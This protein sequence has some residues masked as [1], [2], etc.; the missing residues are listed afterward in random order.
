[1]FAPGGYVGVDI[2]F[3][4]S[5]YLITSILVRDISNGRFSL[6]TF[7]ERRCR[8]ILPPLV[9]VLLGT[10][11][12]AYIYLL[13]V[14][15]IDYAKSLCATVFSASN[16]Y[17]WTK[18]SYFSASG[19]LLHTWS[20][21]VEEQFYVVFPL[22][23]ATVYRYKR[24]WMARAIVVVAILSFC[25]S[26]Y[27]QYRWPT[28]N[29][30]MPTT[31]AWEL[32]VGSIVALRAFPHP[33]KPLTRAMIAALGLASMLVPILTYTAATP[34]PGLAALPPC[35][36]AALVI[37]SGEGEK[38]TWLG[39]I[40]SLRP[41]VFVG[42]ISYSL[43]LVHWPLI[44]FGED[45]F[46]HFVSLSHRVNLLIFIATCLA[47]AS[48]MYYFVEN[49]FRAKKILG[50]K[51]S[52]LI[53]S[54]IGIAAIAAVGLSML[55]LHGMASRYP[56]EALKIARW[57]RDPSEIAQFRQGTCFVAFPEPYSE[58][59]P[60]TCLHLDPQRK[61]VLLMGDSHAAAA[62]A[63]LSAD[64][65]PANLLQATASN[66]KPF[67]LK[68]ART[69][70]AQLMAYV[71]GQFLPRNKVDA[72]VVTAR[73]KD[74]DLVEL[75]HLADWAHK[76]NTPLIVLGPAVEYDAPLPVLLAYG[77]RAH[78][79]GLANKHRITL[80]DGL[81][82]QMQTDA[83]NLWHVPYISLVNATCTA[84]TC[85]ETVPEHGA[86]GGDSVPML[87]D[88]DHYTQT[89]AAY[90]FACLRQSGQLDAVPR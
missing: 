41:I 5:G 65:A 8:R 75:A 17:F 29:F 12:L 15:L 11:A 38:P 72:I 74:S 3:V 16:I 32:M 90:I 69:D 68:G 20:L 13:P 50:S 23:L 79:A 54:G 49:P 37:I 27:S 36:G 43:Y 9:V 80:I 66:C 89:G 76:N 46:L 25:L 83:A 70:C 56:P 87:F 51:P 35:L 1:M 59:S 53:A 82:K 71:F 84:G 24:D 22:F 18:E 44:I 34:F 21:S 31:R 48:L 6:S 88:H 4:I 19:P 60:A 85:V 81:D 67:L 2:F 47:L 77:I 14:D 55:A 64:I 39:S 10:I 61:N 33:E 57:Y 7:Y 40:L 52:I 26:V 63:A 86:A 78:D 73:W 28:T 45:G 42:S 62:W 58:Y 30:Y